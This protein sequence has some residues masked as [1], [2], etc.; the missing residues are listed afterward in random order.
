VEDVDNEESEAA[1]EDDTDEEAP[2]FEDG[3]EK[4]PSL[5]LASIEILSAAQMP[6]GDVHVE[7]VNVHKICLRRIRAAKKSKCAGTVLPPDQLDKFALHEL[8]K[9]VDTSPGLGSVVVNSDALALMRL[10]LEQRLVRLLED[11]QLAAAHAHRVCVRPADI[12]LA[13]RTLGICLASGLLPAD[14][15]AARADCELIAAAAATETQTYSESP[16]RACTHLTYRDD[17]HQEEV[18]LDWV[19]LH[20][21]VR[22]LDGACASPQD[23]LAAAVLR[24]LMASNT[25]TQGVCSSSDSCGDDSPSEGQDR[26]GLALPR[27]A[28]ETWVRCLCDEVFGQRVPTEQSSECTHFRTH[29]ESDAVF[30][31]LQVSVE[32]KMHTLLHGA[33]LAVRHRGGSWLQPKDL[34]LSRRILN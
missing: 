20:Q 28:F 26:D 10:A 6:I 2:P 18:A 14:A 24:E 1:S 16:P 11:A 4:A 30:T 31:A 9:L 25:L 21:A 17:T 27:K 3:T 29:F 32:A 13:L 15:A 8:G 33:A 19:E 12:R 23:H 5:D 34:Q 7:G 22:S